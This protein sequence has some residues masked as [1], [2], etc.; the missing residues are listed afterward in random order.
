ML[1]VHIESF[2]YSDQ[3]V[4][5]QLR[6][7]I[8]TNQHLAVLG[9]SGSGKST[10]L[11][12][13]YGLLDLPNGEITWERKR[14]LGASD[15]LIPGHEFMKLVAQEYDIMPFIS[16]AENIGSFLSKQDVESDEKRIDELLE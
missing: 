4:L 2:N 10:L 9:E 6:F 12:L 14:L 11:H 16:V 13:I 1:K 8:D 15:K 3:E 5:K 7:A